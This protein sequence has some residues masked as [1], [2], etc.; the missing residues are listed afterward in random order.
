MPLSKFKETLYLFDLFGVRPALYFKGKKKTGTGFGLCL[1]FLLIC[2]TFICFFFFGQDLY[3]RT[4]PQLLY[5]EEYTP[6]PEE[7]VLDPETSPFLLEINNPVGSVYYKDPKLVRMTV[8]QLIISRNEAGSM[9]HLFQTYAMETCTGEHLQKLDDSTRNYFLGLNLAD[10]FCIPRE[11]KNL[12]IAG[13]FDQKIFKTIQFKISLCVGEDSCLPAEEIRAEMN[14]GFVGL[15]FVDYNINPGDYANPK[16]PQPKEVFTNFMVDNQKEVNVYF[17][18]NVLETDDGLVFK[19]PSQQK[20][21]TFNSETDMQFNSVDKDFFSIYLK[22]SQKTSIHH[23]SYRKLQEVMAQI[24]GFTNFF[25]IFAFLLNYFYCHLLIISETITTVF[26]VKVLYEDAESR[27]NKL[28]ALQQSVFAAEENG[29]NQ[30]N[31]NKI[32]ATHKIHVKPAKTS[33]YIEESGGKVKKTQGMQLG[34]KDYAYYFTGLFR[35]PERERKKIVIREGS[36]ILAKCLDV[37]YIIQKFYEIE[38]LKR[39]LLSEE[40]AQDFKKLPKPELKIILNKQSQ[41]KNIFVRRDIF[42]ES[43]RKRTEINEEK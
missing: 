26:S 28:F 7:F 23:R 41:N 33:K 21:L 16:K 42:I 18:K 13:S 37:K 11:L 40:E 5:N 20:I 27:R 19:S 15:Y 34:F 10:F 17:Q 12:S 43:T 38:K 4:N 30:S 8:T 39:I 32:T 22:M 6:L 36:R 14:K 1:S 2:F 31:N 35:T 24:G 3:N 25:W 29:E 9:T